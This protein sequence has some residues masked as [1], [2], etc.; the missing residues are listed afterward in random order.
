M[1]NIVDPRS[2]GVYGYERAP[3]QAAEAFS[4]SKMGIIGWTEKGEENTPVLV[5]SYEEFTRLLGGLNTM[6]LVAISVQAFFDT[7]GQACW[8]VRVT[9][10]D[11]VSAFV[12]IDAPAKWTFT[13]KGSG[14]YGNSV[15]VR[16]VGNRN[17]PLLPI[18]LPMN[19]RTRLVMNHC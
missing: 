14:V 19:S 8:V 3:A 4:P 9:P 11:S 10:S 5:R 6:G 13:S 7:G 12:D 16:V 18:N 2:A 1:A 15:K 17:S